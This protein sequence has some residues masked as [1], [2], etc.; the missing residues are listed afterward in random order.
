MWNEIAFIEA[1]TLLFKRFQVAV[2]S[3]VIP[4]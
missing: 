4:A 2:C 1:D 3:L